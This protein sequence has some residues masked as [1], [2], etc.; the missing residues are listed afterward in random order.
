MAPF[1][2]KTYTRL[3]TARIPARYLRLTD[4]SVKGHK[5]WLINH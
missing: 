4:F 5:A 2:E 1:P 3:S